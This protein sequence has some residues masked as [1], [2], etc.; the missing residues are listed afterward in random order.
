MT[1]R[2]PDKKAVWNVLGVMGISPGSGGGPKTGLSLM[3]P[4]GVTML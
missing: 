1:A 2:L 4:I 3:Y